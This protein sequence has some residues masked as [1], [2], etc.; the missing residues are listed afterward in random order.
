M[1]PLQRYQQNL[2]SGEYSADPAQRQAVEQVQKLFH[3]VEAMAQSKSGF[4]PGLLKTLSRPKT[5]PVKGIYFWGGVGRGKTYIVDMFYDCLTLRQKRRIH[6]HRFMQLVHRQLKKLN[7]VE[8]PLQ[9]VADEFAHDAKVLCFDEFHVSDITDAML[10]SG[11]LGALFDRGVILVATSNQPPDEL[12]WDG[13][14]RERFL[15]AIELLK[16]HTDVVRLDFG[17][18]YRLRYL[19]KAKIYHYP[20]NAAAGRMLQTNY[21]SMAPETGRM[22]SA[23]EIEGRKIPVVRFV[24]GVVWF[25]FHAICDGPRAAADYIEIGRQY[26]TV[27]I[28]NVPCFSDSENDLARRFM[29]LVDEFYDRNVKLII[30][31]AARA[32]QLY[33]GKYLEKPFRRT[34]SRLI[35]MQTC[36][37]LARR[38]I[39]D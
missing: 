7:H 29:T 26:Q 16:T 19:E 24:D 32:E 8:D 11:L 27:L 12:Y 14:Q 1:T 15:P 17:V 3:A 28:A 22:N 5:S 21:E 34:V 38:H 37:Y 18:D 4:W 36:D 13:L 10:L 20:L 30:T 39:C 33:F 23:I 2:D 35:E 31:A 25:D 6:F 9:I